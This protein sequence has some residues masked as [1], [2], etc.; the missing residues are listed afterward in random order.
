M[1]S[2]GD[3]G[4]AASHCPKRFRGP[5]FGEKSTKILSPCVFPLKR[6]GR[7][8]PSPVHPGVP[9]L[10]ETSTTP[11]ASP[12]STIAIL[13]G[14]PGC[15]GSEYAPSN[16]GAALS[17]AK[18]AGAAA[19][20]RGTAARTARRLS[21]ESACADS[22]EAGE[23]TMRGV[24]GSDGTAEKHSAAHTRAANGARSLRIPSFPI[25]IRELR[26]APK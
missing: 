24:A 11:S 20:R 17:L 7:V 1:P 18:E 3:E 19:N 13:R 2:D 21:G 12:S 26:E 4:L 8:G 9:S 5:P 16:G 6:H 14:Q 23:L 10:P 22:D 25:P 15:L